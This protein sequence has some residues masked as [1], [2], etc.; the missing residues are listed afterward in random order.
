MPRGTQ[1]YTIGSLSTMLNMEGIDDVVTP[2]P[3]R[4]QV[5]GWP[6][7]AVPTRAAWRSNG[8]Y[9]A[10]S[11]D[12]F[13]G[14]AR[15][16]LGQ[17]TQFRDIWNAQPASFKNDPARLAQAKK[18]GRYPVDI[19]FI[20]DVLVMPAAAQAEARR[21]GVLVDDEVAVPTPQQQQ[22][23]VLPS[24]EVVMPEMVITEKR[25]VAK[26]KNPA[27]AL[28]SMLAGGLV[29]MWHHPDIPKLST[30]WR[31]ITGRTVG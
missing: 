26:L 28:S 30:W 27:L 13:S 1:V 14:I 8:T 3:A 16:Y 29:F 6:K 5:S 7:P 19:L 21:L 4:G 15:T 20:G 2:N 11:G 24:G 23:V 12:T 17:Y 10:Q 31:A 25:P 22:P 18:L 9:V